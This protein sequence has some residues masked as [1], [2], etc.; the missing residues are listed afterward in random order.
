M[1]WPT[2]KEKEKK[3]QDGCH[4]AD[5]C[6][7]KSHTNE[8]LLHHFLKRQQNVWKLLVL[9]LIL[10]HFSDWM[11][12]VWPDF[13]RGRDHSHRNITCHEALFN[14][15]ELHI[16]KTFLFGWRHQH[17][18]AD[19]DLRLS[20]FRTSVWKLTGLFQSQS[21]DFSSSSGWKARLSS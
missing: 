4:H 15:Q 2:R 10:H 14:L 13:F 18:E 8:L 12:I 16:H 7:H 3:N 6:V 11:Q 1:S 17:R 5:A 9:H 21:K 19:R 20:S